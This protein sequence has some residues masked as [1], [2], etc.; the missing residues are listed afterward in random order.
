MQCGTLN[1][2]RPRPAPRRFTTGDTTHS[3]RPHSLAPPS[4]TPCPGAGHR[5]P[6]EQPQQGPRPEGAAPHL[7]VIPLGGMGEIGK[8][9]T[10]YRF[11][12]EIMVVDAG[13]AFPRATRWAST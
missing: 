4:L 11:E 1:A 6:H 9:I 10:A 5:S 12:D 13:L 2:L 8:N 3:L 7:E